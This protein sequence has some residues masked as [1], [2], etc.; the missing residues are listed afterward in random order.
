MHEHDPRTEPGYD[1]DW[2]RVNKLADKYAPKP[3][4]EPH[5]ETEF[6]AHGEHGHAN[7][8]AQ[9]IALIHYD[10]NVETAAFWSSHLEDENGRW[11]DATHANVNIA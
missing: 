7:W 6:E 11:L 10:A 5:T 8:S 2:Q 3:P 1:E 9:I 4:P